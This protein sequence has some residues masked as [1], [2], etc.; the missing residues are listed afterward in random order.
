MNRKTVHHQEVSYTNETKRIEND[1]RSS[2]N[3]FLVPGLILEIKYLQRSH[4]KTSTF[5][6]SL[7]MRAVTPQMTGDMARINVYFV[8][9]RAGTT[10]RALWPIGACPKF[11]FVVVDCALH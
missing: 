4:S 8:P 1:I 5:V 3:D 10:I 7:V 9:H 11:L 2:F 6:F